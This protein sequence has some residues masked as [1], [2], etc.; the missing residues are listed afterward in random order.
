MPPFMLAAF[1]IA[2]VICV[3]I[4]V[5]EY[6]RYDI[7]RLYG[8]RGYDHSHDRSNNAFVCC[9]LR[10]CWARLNQ[11]KKVNNM[12][13]YL[14]DDEEAMPTLVVGVLLL[15][16]LAAAA[17]VNNVDDYFRRAYQIGSKRV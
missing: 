9:G 3:D 13:R 8:D 5:G 17:L 10:W 2:I 6:R 12:F 11:F 16:A 4:I 7:S 14:Y 15:A 1:I